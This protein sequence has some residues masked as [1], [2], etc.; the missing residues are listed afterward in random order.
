ME[1]IGWNSAISRKTMSKPTQWLLK[2]NLIKGKT[3]DFGCG[4]GKDADLL[5]CDRYDPYFF[6]NPPKNKYDTIICQYGLNIL[7]PKK[8]IKTINQMK[9]LIN[10][11]GSIFITV[12]RDIKTIK[13]GKG[14]TKQ[15]PV[16]LNLRSIYHNANFEIYKVE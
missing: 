9:N 10:K 7:P 16:Y 8:R 6:P 4:K 3:L 11:N 5:K 15:Y 13:K 12:R 1:V 2:N 14:N